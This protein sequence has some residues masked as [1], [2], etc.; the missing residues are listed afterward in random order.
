MTLKE[1]VDVV[2]GVFTIVSLVVASS[3]AL[4]GLSAWREETRK[5]YDLD[6]ARRTLLAVYALRDSIIRFW[7]EVATM[8]MTEATERQRRAV[9]PDPEDTLES[10]AVDLRQRID[11][12][13]NDIWK[14]V[15]LARNGAGVLMLEV[16]ASWGVEIKTA[17]GRLVAVADDTGAE[18]QLWLAAVSMDD[19]INTTWR[20][21][22]EMMRGERGKALAES[23][24]QAVTTAEELLKRKMKL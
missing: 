12:C 10:G 14:P 8:L 11:N 22:S 5:K 20:A 1:W 9:M 3:V 19:D 4:R 15:E 23:V 17:V 24:R 13:F 18:T 16:E 2:V 6:L 7:R 21:S